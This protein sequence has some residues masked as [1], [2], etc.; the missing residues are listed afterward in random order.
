MLPLLH[1]WYLLGYW[2]GK[3]K[4]RDSIYN[5]RSQ[6]LIDNKYKPWEVFLGAFFVKYY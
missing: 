2:G 6:L 4:T 5:M 3:M 1:H